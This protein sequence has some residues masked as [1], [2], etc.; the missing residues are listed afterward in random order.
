[1]F[2]ITAKTPSPVGV[3]ATPSH[4][5]RQGPTILTET[6][7]VCDSATGGIPIIG[8]AA[9]ERSFPTNPDASYG[10]AIDHSFT[11]GSF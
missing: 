3:A 5:M 2:P 7:T 11:S 9:W 8:F 4:T 10:R 6:G 1:M